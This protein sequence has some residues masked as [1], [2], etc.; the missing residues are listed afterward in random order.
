MEQMVA[1]QAD[2]RF[3]SVQVPG[4]VDLERQVQWES[5]VIPANR[6]Q[7]LREAYSIL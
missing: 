3:Y 1:L 2:W 5:Y 4:P 7:R 6:F